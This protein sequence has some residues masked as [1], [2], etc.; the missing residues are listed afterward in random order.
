MIIGT[1]HQYKEIEKGEKDVSYENQL[2]IPN[3]ANPILQIQSSTL[4]VDQ[5]TNK[6]HAHFSPNTSSSTEKTPL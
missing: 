4:F 5:H 6:L 1:F 2:K 3:P